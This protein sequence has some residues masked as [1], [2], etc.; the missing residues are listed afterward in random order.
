MLIRGDLVAISRQPGPALVVFINQ[1]SKGPERLSHIPAAMLQLKQR[2]RRTVVR[3]W[4]DQL[5]DGLN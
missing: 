2:R 1:A 4:L 3:T 5:F